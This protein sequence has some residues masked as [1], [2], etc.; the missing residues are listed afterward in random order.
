MVIFSGILLILVAFLLW[1]EYSLY[2][3]REESELCEITRFVRN[4]RD[5]MAC[6]LELPSAW[7]GEYSSDVLE[8]VGFLPKIRSGEDVSLAYEGIK[9]QLLLDPD[10]SDELSTLFAGLGDGYLEGELALVD[11]TIAKLD[12]AGARL[13]PEIK[14]KTRAAGAM[15][16]ALAMGAVILII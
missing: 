3:K 11:K 13:A 2:L 8:R 6:Y 14:N 5:R 15:L 4:M 1:R 12:S 16:G 10:I 9:E 7:A